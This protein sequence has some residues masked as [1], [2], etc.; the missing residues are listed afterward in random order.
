MTE[1][2]NDETKTKPAD[3]AD[4]V[5]TSAAATPPAAGAATP[6]A[7]AGAPAA[8][9][10]RQ[11]GVKE[12]IIFKWKLL[13][14]AGDVMLTLFK[15]TEREDVDAQFERVQREGYYTNLKI[16]EADAK[17]PQ[18]KKVKD[19]FDKER[20]QMGSV[21]EKKAREEKKPRTKEVLGEPKLIRIGRTKAAIA[22][23]AAAEAKKLAKKAAKKKPKKA[24]KKAAKKKAKT[25]KVAKTATKKAAKK[26]VA[27]KKVTKAVK[28]KAKAKA[29]P[30]KK[31]KKATSPAT[32]RRKR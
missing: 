4:A 16:V 8:P 1:K 27:K 24:S 26:V 14:G 22:K 20:Q 30:A 11:L 9:P 12:P 19:S 15:S 5:A 3:G 2:A 6:A 10:R 18:S 23:A 7:G 29:A 13:G 31:K 21:A 28:K 17:V 25:K 32:K